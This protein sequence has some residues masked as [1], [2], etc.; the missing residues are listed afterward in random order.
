MEQSKV[1]IHAKVEVDKGTKSGVS[2]LKQDEE[3]GHLIQEGYYSSGTMRMSTGE[4]S[5]MVCPKP[6]RVKWHSHRVQKV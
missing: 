1:G 2:Q 5:Y 4:W 3:G 6:K